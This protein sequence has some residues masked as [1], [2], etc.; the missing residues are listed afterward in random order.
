[1]TDQQRQEYER[2]YYKGLECVDK[3]DFT[4]A[5][6][7]LEPLVEVGAVSA[8][9]ELAGVYTLVEANIPFDHVLNQL[10]KFAEK[11]QT[12]PYALVELAGILIGNDPN[13][14]FLAKHGERHITADTIQR[15]KILIERAINLVN[16]GNGSMNFVGLSKAASILAAYRGRVSDAIETA[17]INP[18]DKGTFNNLTQTA[19]DS[20]VMQLECEEKALM[21]AT[22][23]NNKDGLSLPEEY[24]NLLKES[25][26]AS[27]R[28]LTEIDDVLMNYKRLHHESRGST[29]E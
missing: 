25:V 1:M 10:N 7:Y 2:Q 13:N 12:H 23:L 8:M 6:R 20:L 11:E 9:R 21:S 15:G 4:N 5:V 26:E 18:I 27:K 22:S 24:I 19:K 28:Y 3:R 17:M 14:E 29:Q 16:E